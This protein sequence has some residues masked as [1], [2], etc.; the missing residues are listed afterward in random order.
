MSKGVVLY[1]DGGSREN[2]GAAGSGIH[3]YLFEFSLPKKGTGNSK[4]VLTQ[5]GYLTLEEYANKVGVKGANR[6][7][8]TGNVPVME[9]EATKDDCLSYANSNT[10]YE[11]TPIEYID[12]WV[13]YEGARTNNYA[14]LGAVRTALENILTSVYVEHPE[15]LYVQIHSD[16][17]YVVKGFMEYM[18]RWAKRGWKRSNSDEPIPNI[19]MW[20]ALHQLRNQYEATGIK[21]VL[22]WVKGHSGD[23]GNESADALATIAVC[24]ASN[25]LPEDKSVFRTLPAAG[26]WKDDHEK[27]VMLF[28]KYAFFNPADIS[29]EL[30]GLFFTGATSLPLELL[31]SPQSD[32]GFSLV[33]V[34]EHE[35]EAFTPLLTVINKQTEVLE[36]MSVITAVD[37]DVLSSHA[38]LNDYQIAGADSFVVDASARYEMY[39]ARR[40]ALRKNIT[41]VI[42]PPYISF[43]VEDVK[44]HLIQFY[45]WY[46]CRDERL[47]V[48]DLT[49]QF[50]YTATKK[51]KNVETEYTELLPRF[52]VGHRTE[53][54]DVLYAVDKT[55][56]AHTPV[57]LVLGRDLPDR[58]TL[59]RL[60]T[61]EPRVYLLTH[62][63]AGGVF[64][65]ATIIETNQGWILSSSY[66]SSLR[67]VA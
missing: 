29:N 44:Q 56:D 14:E 9:P 16:S 31:G 11:V 3:G 53:T 50:Y 45:N 54:V 25:K 65:Y 61:D 59:K 57:I 52:K 60:E 62:S 39:T 12:S 43:R 63:E 49:E 30:N 48:T 15:L 58:N 17:S 36:E 27:P 38:V 18:D 26:Y 8:L 5:H 32:A 35:S 13:A 42:N 19:E 7:A 4:V 66:Y 1:A 46:V 64:R 55:T 41:E 24:I 34:F 37:T 33:K 21:L 2:P 22:D 6:K 23:L 51:V 28:N 47:R 40:A 20:Q 67:I 10:P